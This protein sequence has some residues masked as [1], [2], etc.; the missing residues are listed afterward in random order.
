MGK[1]VGGKGNGLLAGLDPDSFV[2]EKFLHDRG[3]MALRTAQ[4]RRLRGEDP[5]YY[6][7]GKSVKYRVGDIVAWLNANR[8]QAAG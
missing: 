5:P 2:C 3:I 6:K 7:V 1:P 8:V 4:G